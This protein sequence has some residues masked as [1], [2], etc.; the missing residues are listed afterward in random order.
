MKTEILRYLDYLRRIVLAW[1]VLLLVGV[2]AHVI[3]L[4]SRGKSLWLI[5][6]RPDEARDNGYHLYRYIRRHRPDI[7]IQYVIRSDSADIGKIQALGDYVEYGSLRHYFLYALCNVALSTHWHGAAPYGVAGGLL[8]KFLPRKVTVHLRHGVGKDHYTI[9]RRAMGTENAILICGAEPEYLYLKSHFEGAPATLAFTGLAR[10]D[11]LHDVPP[12]K[13]QILFMPTFRR[14]LT[15]LARLGPETSLKK[16]KEDKY[17]VCINQVL[18]SR[19]LHEALERW[20]TTLVF[21]PHYE[22][23]RYLTAFDIQ[24]PRIVIASR[25]KFDVQ[26]LLIESAL[27]VTDFSSVFFDFAY[28]GKPVLYYHFD[29]EAYRKNHYK[30]GY[31][32]YEEHGFGPVLHTSDGLIQAMIDA[33]R[34]DF[35]NPEKYKQRADSFFGHRSRNNCE[36]ILAVVEQKVQELFR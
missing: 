35:A 14:W 7:N 11:A 30:E 17:F 9:F 5:A 12:P 1:P 19:R 18:N 26:T 21:F 4:F 33:M 22:I 15:N 23:H 16:F 27:L 36:R 25:K 32:S 8:L 24:N 2:I 10:F 6:E 28:M 13:R 29:T 34:A 20:D 3:R 31:F